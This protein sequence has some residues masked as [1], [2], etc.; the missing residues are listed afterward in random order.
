[1]TSVPRIYFVYHYPF[2]SMDKRA[3]GYTGH[4]RSVRR[5]IS[6]N[7][8]YSRA[9][10]Y[11]GSSFRGRRASTK[12]PELKFYDT[13]VSLTTVTPTGVIDE[14]L[15]LVPQGTGEEDRIGRK[16]TIKK[17]SLNLQLHLPST[18]SENDMTD[19]IRFIVY[20]DKQCNGAAATPGGDGDVTG[21]LQDLRVTSFN[22]LNNK[23]RFRI[24]CSKTFAM[25]AT[26]GGNETGTA[27]G[28][29]F[30]THEFHIDCNIPIEMSATT[31]AITNVRS[32]NI[33]VLYLS[34]N[35]NIQVT[36]D[37]RIRYSDD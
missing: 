6:Y 10:P 15:N 36:Y 20:H 35:G 31:G 26:A 30:E 17:L 13:F 32:N 1:M 27:S 9:A 18:T 37:T 21:I 29:M 16:F 8:P 7:A 19:A 28:A 34:N 11:S 5:R 22:R 4:Q 25:A 2:L 3:S 14:S 24:L 33:G 12:I 23:N